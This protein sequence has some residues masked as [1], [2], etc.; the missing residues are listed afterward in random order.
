MLSTVRAADQPRWG[1]SPELNGIGASL[2]AT[3]LREASD[4]G[5]L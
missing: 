4:H 1:D 2:A 3:A 5:L